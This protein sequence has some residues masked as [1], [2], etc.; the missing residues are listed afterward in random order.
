MAKKNNTFNWAIGGILILFVILFI[1]AKY[2]DGGGAVV[3]NPADTN[4]DDWSKGAIGANVTLIEY[5]DFQC[6]A[7]KSFY[8]IL[9]SLEEKYNDR[10]KFV[11]R[12]FPLIQIHPNAFPAARASEAAG[13]QGKFWEMHD[14]LFEN[15]N[16]WSGTNR[17]VESIFEGYA[18]EIGL[19]IEKYKS[20]YGSSE[21][22][23]AVTDDLN[24]ANRLGL[25]S[26]P[27]FLLDGKKIQVPRSLEAFEALLDAV[28]VNAPP[29]EVDKDDL[30][31]AAD[32]HEHADFAVYLNGKKIDF[33]IDKYQSDEPED[34]DENHDHEEDHAH[35]LDPYVHIHNNKGEII[36]KH[37]TGIT[38]GYFFE[39]LGMKFSDSCFET[40]DG[41]QFCKDDK[42]SLK[43]FVNGVRNTRNTSYVIKD[44][45]QILVS[46]GPLTDSNLKS[47]LDSVTDEACIYSETCPERGEAP[48]EKCVGGIE[49]GC[50][51]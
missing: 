41:T 33:S 9:Q 4:T 22:N 42:N 30:A 18:E 17:N 45:D 28:L 10:V 6:P 49:T 14:L 13:L 25:N 37:K 20:D 12:H 44:L 36:H 31:N 34:E 8:P 50:T 19:D 11:Y 32:T 39:T 51:Q 7:C 16:T 29:P 27:S 24:S 40:D 35:A 47:Q 26:T 15:Q 21:V 43:F 2:S 5:A 1:W 38:L 3:G 23:Q 48:E 46:Y